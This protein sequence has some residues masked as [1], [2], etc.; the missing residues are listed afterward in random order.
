MT[1]RYLLKQWKELKSGDFFIFTRINDKYL[2]K[3]LSCDKTSFEFIDI[4]TFDKDDKT[5][6]KQ[7]SRR[8]ICY[9][10]LIDHSSFHLIT[11]NQEEIINN[12]AEYLI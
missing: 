12:Y 8:Y 2:A 4:C 3:V 6:R 9:F 1:D 7:E 10:I 5:Q 11:R